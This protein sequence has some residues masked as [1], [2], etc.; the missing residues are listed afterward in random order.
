MISFKNPLKKYENHIFNT[1]YLV[2][3]P[4]SDEKDAFLEAV[5]RTKLPYDSSK[6]KILKAEKGTYEVKD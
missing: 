3:V 5:K 6:L 4:N 1:S 2:K